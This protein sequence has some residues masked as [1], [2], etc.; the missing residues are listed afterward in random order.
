MNLKMSHPDM[1][2]IALAVW[3]AARRE[4]E[5]SR[6]AIAW[7][8]RNRMAS[9]AGSEA[10]CAGRICGQLLQEVAGVVDRS[11]PKE[12]CFDN[13]DYCR[14]F[15]TSCLVW[16]D[17]LADPTDGANI[18]HR[19][20]AMPAWAAAMQPAALLGSYFFYRAPPPPRLASS[21]PAR[22]PRIFPPNELPER[23]GA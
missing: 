13:P 15:A 8:I 5:V 23:A 7:C 4:P 17:D 3:H 2:I 10:E 16:C 18:F 14:A 12:I 6:R 9:H 11:A 1:Q 20:D 22:L 19:H 21:S